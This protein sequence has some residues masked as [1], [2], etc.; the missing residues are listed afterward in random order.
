MEIAQEGPKECPTC[1][2]LLPGHAGHRLAS[3]LAD[4]ATQDQLSGTG[5]DGDD[6]DALLKNL[7][8]REHPLPPPAPEQWK[9]VV[10]CASEQHRGELLARFTS[11]GLTCRVLDGPFGGFL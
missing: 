2:Q 1:G 7:G 8:E 10:E 9:L 11:E 5:Y 3:V 6:L 4:L